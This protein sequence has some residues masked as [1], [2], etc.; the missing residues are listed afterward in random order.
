MAVK[1]RAATS[2]GV[3]L[4]L[5][6]V[7]DED[8]LKEQA[9]RIN[10]RELERKAAL[11]DVDAKVALEKAREEAAVAKERE[12]TATRLARQE[13]YA[14]RAKVA[15]VVAIFCAHSDCVWLVLGHV[16]FIL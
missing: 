15:P 5:R 7:A 13:E 3:S 1:K 11:E 9:G 8:R 12:V 16:F 4:E 2:S 6:R 14:I 10:R